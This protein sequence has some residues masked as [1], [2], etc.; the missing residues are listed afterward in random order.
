MRKLILVAATAAALSGCSTYDDGYGRPYYADNYYRDGPNYSERAL[1]R[2][3][4]VYRG[5]DGR[6]Y[7]R[8]SDGTTGLNVGGA[9]GGL[10]GNIALRT[11]RRIQWDDVNER[12]VGD[13]DADKL[14]TRK[15]RKPWKLA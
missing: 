8:R 3:D 11:G 5:R 2:R 13:K 4:R 7:C 9:A 10:L 1:S 14:V 15:Y 12:I 6:Y